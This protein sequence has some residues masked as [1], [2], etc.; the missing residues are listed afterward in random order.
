MSAPKISGVKGMND[1]LAPQ[2]ETWQRIE[3]VAR[4]LFGRYGFSEV[5]TPIVEH[6]ELFVRSVGEVTDIVGK[7]MYT[8]N[9]KGDRSITMRPEGTA[10]AARAYI[11]HGVANTEPLTRWFYM[12]PMFRYERMKTGRYRQFYQLGAEAYGALDP[13]QDV[14]V[15][16]LCHAF[17]KE[18]GVPDV[19]LHL[20]SLGDGS[21]RP[22]YLEA[23]R[24]HFRPLLEVM[25]DDA[26]LAFERNTMRLLDSKEEK[27]QQAIA[28][29]PSILD[30]LDEGSQTHFATVRRLLEKLG[31]P[32][33]IDRRLVRGL[34]YY[35]RTTFEFIYQPKSGENAL[36]T[37][38]TVCGGGRYDRLVHELGGPEKP[39][40]GFAMGLDRLV[41]LLESVKGTS[42]AA[43][44]LFVGTFEGPERD[45]AIALVMALRNEGFHVDFDPRGGKLGK[46]KER[47]SKLNAAW[48]ATFGADELTQKKL[49]LDNMRLPKD[50]PKEQ[51]E[52][53]F[54]GLR[55]W[56]NDKKERSS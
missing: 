30:H 31:I 12:G 46:Q 23:L 37:A 21:T 16:A 8:F 17:F 29:A 11:E 49:K 34:D 13:A 5:R 19:V 25:S 50:A 48:F 26:K 35:T 4:S 1:L 36:G 10:P 45:E 22:Q 41:M 3:Q 24:T 53:S 33:E 18:I 20:N 44:L 47:A 54:D 2:I 39:A 9:D 15:I 27:L 7:E 14:E 32:Y 40:V 51:V 43:P 52:V 42:R 28:S 6:T 56:L 55:A 38:G